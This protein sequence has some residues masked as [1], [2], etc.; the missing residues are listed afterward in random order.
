MIRATG[1]L[2]LDVGACALATTIVLGTPLPADAKS[3]PRLAVAQAGAP[4]S[5]SPAA[6]SAP[7]E[8]DEPIPP[9][10]GEAPQRAEPPDQTAAR[11]RRITPDIV[12]PLG[13][14]PDTLNVRLARALD[15]AGV[16]RAW[17]APDA[18]A[19]GMWGGG[20][21]RGPLFDF[22]SAAPERAPDV[23]CILGGTAVGAAGRAADLTL[24]AGQRARFGVRRGLVANPHA[25][26]WEA[27]AEKDAFE[28]ALRALSEQP[29]T[30]A[31]GGSKGS[32]GKG[33]KVDVKSEGNVPPDAQ[34]LAAF[35]L[36]AMQEALT[37]REAALANASKAGVDFDASF[38]RLFHAYACGDSASDTL[39]TRENEALL[40]QIDLALLHAGGLDFALALDEARAKTDSLQLGGEYHLEAETPLGTVVLDGTIGTRYEDPG[41]Y[42]LIIDAG[43]H[44]TY[45]GGATTYSSAA[46]ISAIIEVAG[47]DEYVAADSERPSWG[48]A[49]LGYAA[50]VDLS[51]N[52]TYRGVGLS[53][54][55][56]LAGVG[57]L[58]DLAGDDRYEAVTFAQGAARYG[59]GVLGDRM[60]RDRYLAFQ[61][62]QGFGGPQG[63]GVL[64]DSSGNDE[65]R[66]EDSVVRF[67]SAQ[68]PQHNTS[69]V[70][71]AGCGLRADYSDGHSLAGGVGILADGGG[72][73][74]YRCGVFGQGVGYWYGVGALFDAAGRDSFDGV[75]YAQGA[76]AHFAFGALL[77]IGGNDVFRATE[78]M[79]QGA[80]HDFSVGLLLDYGGN[81]TH[82]APN[83]SLGG[84]NA[85]GVGLFFDERGDDLYRASGEITFGR[86]DTAVPP[87][88][89]RDIFPTTGIFLDGGGADTYETA[90][91]MV[92]EGKAWRQE[93]TK[94]PS[95]T[96]EIGVG[97][98]RR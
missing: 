59:V 44:D 73:D 16:D 82:T 63:V 88:G 29:V 55:A 7:P 89:L 80:G 70:Q 32:K 18:R 2:L 62:A 76:A 92:G 61:S 56:G 41:P 65:Y 13:F 58:L 36:S 34:R 68:T 24:F 87:G 78:N 47:D 49:C 5:Q 86:G 72:N 45:W 6:Q 64:A 10:P 91:T 71:G 85:N 67:P 94:L 40:A 28:R 39:A 31:K 43:G 27:A 79:A 51:G 22:L 14:P 17:L 77:D 21:G 69:L 93:G 38:G 97:E 83:L 25:G 37:W 23:L 81:D 35:L 95:L 48:G 42:L 90:K 84:G 33:S 8:R 3:K 66:A 57:I 11:P 60:G 46:P 15:H 52:D 19:I 12:V 50:L 54:G 75:W 30:G 98:D 74:V 1:K 4:A 20:E 96:T 26:R 53:L 9:L